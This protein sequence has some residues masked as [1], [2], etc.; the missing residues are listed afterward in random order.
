M[1]EDMRPVMRILEAV[2]GLI[3]AA[4]IMWISAAMVD[5]S[6]DVAVIKSKLVG[7]THVAEQNKGKIDG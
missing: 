5:V 4:W 1:H 3:L 7:D 6:K 2:V